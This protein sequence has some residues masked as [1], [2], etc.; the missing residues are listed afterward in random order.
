MRIHLV[1]PSDVSFGTAVITPRWL[2]VLAAA[3]P[4]E[5]GDPLIWNETLDPLDFDRISTG[6]VVGIGVHTSNALRGYAI[7]R[8]ARRR[9]AYVVFGGI[10]PT[11]Y[12][13]ESFERGAAHSVVKGDGD[14]VWSTV[15]PHCK[16]GEPLGTY[17]GGRVSGTSFQPARW[18]LLPAGRSVQ[19]V[20][21]FASGRRRVRRDRGRCR[22]ASWCS[23]RACRAIPPMSCERSS[24]S[25]TRLSCPRLPRR[26]GW[27]VTPGAREHS[28]FIIAVPMLL[29]GFRP[30]R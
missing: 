8:E 22:S 20:P 24:R 17:D 5:Y 29:T 26:S 3:T 27:L 21:N 28:S 13:E 25:T 16:S 14:L 12:P 19:Q 6:D 7:G 4:R 9:G 30:P 10:H 18:D 23:S 2:Y 15:L 11:L 1:N